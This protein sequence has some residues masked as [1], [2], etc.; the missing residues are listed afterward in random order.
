MTTSANDFM[1]KIHDRMQVI[2]DAK[3]FEEWLDP[4]VHEVDEIKSLL[5]PCPPDRLESVEVST[6]VN[7]PRNNREEVLE[8]LKA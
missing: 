4:E 2:L 8:P 7:S 6:L 3:Q 5:K 1:S